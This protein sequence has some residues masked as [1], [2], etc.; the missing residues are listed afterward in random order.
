M[1]SFR[2]VVGIFA[3]SLL[4]YGAPVSA[5]NNAATCILLKQQ[6]AQFSHA[7]NHPNY[8]K[9]KREF[10]KDCQTSANKPNT[11]SKNVAITP[12]KKEPDFSE[13]ERIAAQKEFEKLE[14]EAAAKKEAERLADEKAKREA[15][16]KQ[17][18]AK[19]QEQQRKAEA[20]KAK[21]APK[22]F[23][24]PPLPEPPPSNAL[25]IILPTTI[26]ISLIVF[27]ILGWLVVRRKAH[28]LDTR[29]DFKKP[30]LFNI[31]KKS[32]RVVKHELDPDIYFSFKHIEVEAENKTTIKV[33][34]VVIS[35]Y[36]VFVIHTQKQRGA[37]V[38]TANAAEWKEQSGEESISFDNPI[39][40]N[41]QACMAIG[42]LIGVNV[43]VESV[44]LFNDMAHFKSQLPIIVM[45]RKD[46]SNYILGFKELRYSDDEVD[47]FIDKLNE[48]LG[49]NQ[50]EELEP[51]KEEPT[52][53]HPNKVEQTTSKSVT[54][55]PE[56]GSYQDSVAEIEE[57]RGDS[58]FKPAPEQT[59]LGH[60]TVLAQSLA[61]SSEAQKEIQQASKEVDDMLAKMEEL[62]RS[63]TS[64]STKYSELD[65]NE[66][67]DESID[68]TNPDREQSSLESH[69][70]QQ[71]S[72]IDET[73]NT[74][75]SSED[76]AS[77]LEE[78][79]KTELT[80]DLEKVDIT[81]VRHAD[82]KG[83]AAKKAAE[84]DGMF[85][86]LKHYAEPADPQDTIGNADDLESELKASLDVGKGF[87]S[88]IHDNELSNQQDSSHL[89]EQNS[90]LEKDKSVTSDSNLADD[91]D[92]FDAEKEIA[93][94]NA[95]MK[96]FDESFNS[97]NIAASESVVNE[98]MSNTTT[99][100]D[101]KE[102]NGFSSTQELDDFDAQMMA[103]DAT[104]DMAS[105]DDISCTTTSDDTKEDNGFA[106]TQELDDF[107]A[108]MMA[109]DATRDMASSDDMNNTTTLDDTKEDNGFSSTQELDDFDAQMMA[110]DAAGDM[111]SSDDMSNTTTSDDTNEESGFA[112]TQE[113]DD[114][115]AQ[116]MARDAAR[117]NDENEI[118]AMSSTAS[119]T[120]QS[121]D[122]F[123]LSFD[124]QDTS[125]S[126]ADKELMAALNS[127]QQSATDELQQQTISTSPESDITDS[128]QE[129]DEPTQKEDKKENPF[130]NLSLDPEW[131]P[132][133]AP[134]SKFKSV[135]DD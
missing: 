134:K 30:E 115:D 70:A 67:H 112:S 89:A 43:D 117:E 111:A 69:D 97:S 64:S 68:S 102:D 60:E 32:K 114:F 123:D 95:Q 37:I 83:E 54:N 6:M 31:G 51:V 50:K 121:G 79:L 42:R 8:R 93:A 35:P 110:Q 41:N 24:L 106:S 99:L 14:A 118:S 45:H 94:L 73:D 5:A 90:A 65:V 20:A 98:D 29:I 62:E 10:D 116:M 74:V 61:Q 49:L 63:F 77:T 57:D 23:V 76:D 11:Q 33:E 36:G 103:Q 40:Q 85:D 9:S 66:Q 81:N 87:L 128:S 92:A 124:T 17:I 28:G 53:P 47:G 15:L 56:P 34:R 46:L 130:A 38:G 75:I 88:D 82:F 105:S 39:N 91:S 107:D 7:K 113:L 12:A 27:L 135:D 104:R 59:P 129:L 58:G 109:Q 55:Y 52:T 22:P 125:L 21:A 119:P 71:V 131:A 72:Q 101:T 48:H 122:A 44:I 126:D 3:L 2:V 86:Y 25:G 13:E 96:A 78:H 26:V 100:D 120:E 108:Q 80:N 16:A 18:E 1:F 84:K 127:M 4:M 133:E 132:K 19:E